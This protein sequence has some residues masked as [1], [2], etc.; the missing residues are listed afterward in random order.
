LVSA[1]FAILDELLAVSADCGQLEAWRASKLPALDDHAQYQTPI[2]AKDP[3]YPRAPSVK[4]FCAN[5]RA[6][7][8][9]TAAG[10]T[11]DLNTRLEV[12]IK[13]AKYNETS[14]LGVLAEDDDA[15]YF[16][17]LLKMRTEIGTEKNQVTIFATA[18]VKGKI[19]YYNLYTVYRG[20]D[21]VPAA[22]ARHQRNVPRAARSRGVRETE[23][24]N[25]RMAIC[26]LRRCRFRSNNAPASLSR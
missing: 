18:L 5:A 25:S 23:P 12:A 24:G 26:G 11:P 9:K 1:G 6:Q 19:L 16:G 15:C 17:Q 20:P 2:P 22:L 10:A 3:Y 13:G 14:F 4:Q 21:T 8:E 7:G